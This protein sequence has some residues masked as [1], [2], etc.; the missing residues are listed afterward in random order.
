MHMG[1]TLGRYK[2]KGSRLQIGIVLPQTGNEATPERIAR[3]AEQA[4]A[5]GLDSVWVLDRLLRPVRPISRAP[6]APEEMLPPSYGCVLDPLET[7]AFVA[8]RTERVRLGVSV[9]LALFQHP[10]L[11][12]KR[13]ATLDSL[14]NGR[15]IAGV[16]QGWMA[17]EFT[18]SGV[19]ETRKGAGF[20]E[21]IAAM[22]AV[23]A[24]DP[25]TFAG[26]FYQIPPSEI[27]PKPVQPYGI[28]LLI[29]GYASPAIARAGRLADGFNA[30]VMSREQL[31]GQVATFREAAM[32]AG[33]D[34][35]ALVIIERADAS[36]TDEP[37]PEPERAQFTGTVQQ[38][39]ENLA[40]SADLG[41]SHAF[42][43]VDA[44][45]DTALAALSELRRLVN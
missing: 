45:D 16:A 13:L 14:S 43:S 19:P 41:V 1:Q 23:W 15:V 9:S 7:L 11:L 12:A 21:F 27:G 25:V 5:A 38:W 2:R 32:A 33:R 8:A 22:R 28:P 39:A 18:V 29:G 42:F 34:P 36:L 10:V 30:Y 20:E 44:P 26:R 31:A 17:D 6:G 37:L 24:P 3:V 4:E 35:D 40:Q